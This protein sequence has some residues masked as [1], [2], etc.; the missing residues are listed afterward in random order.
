MI[1]ERM[2]DY[3][4]AS[5]PGKAAIIPNYR[6]YRPLS[7]AGSLARALALN[8]APFLAFY[9]LLGGP[10]AP[11]CSRDQAGLLKQRGMSRNSEGVGRAEGSAGCPRL[12][13]TLL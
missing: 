11:M 6:T 9:G 13:A 2:Y 7:D 1:G 5:R 4:R 12:A 10:R 3:Q 8:F